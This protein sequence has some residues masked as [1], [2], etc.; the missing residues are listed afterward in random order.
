MLLPE[1]EMTD[2]I[3]IAESICQA[4]KG[5]KLENLGA[6]GDVVTVSIGVACRTPDREDNAASLLGAAD[7]ALYAAKRSGKDRVETSG[8]SFN[9]VDRTETICWGIKCKSCSEPV[10]FDVRPYRASG[11]G[12]V[13]L[14]PGAID[15]VHGHKHIYFPRDFR[16]FS[17]DVA[18][19]RHSAPPRYIIENTY[20]CVS[21]FW[22]DGNRSGP[23][24]LIFPQTSANQR[25]I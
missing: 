24:A 10:I 16:F 1:T 12:V 21:R 11:I 15:C 18:I 20:Y 7:C 25:Q 6:I 17:S 23:F 13:N 9:S 19:L 22:A 5:L 14:K 8:P 2:A 4:V 3:L